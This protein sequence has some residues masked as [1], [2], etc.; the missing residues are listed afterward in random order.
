MM[1]A[2]SMLLKRPGL[3]IIAGLFLSFS[4]FRLIFIVFAELLQNSTFMIMKR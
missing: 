4:Y 1:T 2:E 3:R